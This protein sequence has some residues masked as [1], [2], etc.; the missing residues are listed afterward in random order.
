V[1]RIDPNYVNAYINRGNA[2]RKRGEL[3][4]A[5]AD[6][7]AALKLDPQNA[8][9]K[10]NRA[11]AVAE[12]A[13]AGPA[14]GGS[15]K[16][17]LDQATLE[18]CRSGKPSEYKSVMKACS[19]VIAAGDKVPLADRALAYLN[20]GVILGLD[21]KTDKAIDDI[22]QSIAL[23]PNNANAYSHR[24]EL[25]EK[26]DQLDYAVSDYD[27]AIRLD[28]KNGDYLDR[29][30]KDKAARNQPDLA[31]AD[32]TAALVLNPTDD[33]AYIWRGDALRQKGQYQAAIAEYDAALKLQPGMELAVSGRA[34][35]VAAQ[36]QAGATASAAPAGQPPPTEATNV[37]PVAMAGTRI[38]LVIGDSAYAAV[39][40]LPNPARDAKAVAEAL[41]ADGFSD[42][43]LIIDATRAD[44]V[45]ALNDFADKAAG[46][47]WAVVYFAGHG[48]EL[49]GTNY[50][51]PVDAR[52]KTD[53]DVQDEAVSL[54]RVI[55]SI[56]AA[57]KLKLVVLDAC[58]DNPFTVDMRLTGASRAIHRGLARIE[59]S[60]GTLVAYAAKGGEEAIDGDGTANS[61]FAAALVKRL[62]T[63]GLEVGKLF[64]LVHDDVLAATDRE[65]EPFVYG[66]LPGEDF[67]FRPQ[68]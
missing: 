46:A 24:A 52:L 9:A 42:V 55:A 1:L 18:L 48:L 19:V 2:H 17:A 37:S 41:K 64:R 56:Q 36:V 50:L 12:Q 49:D 31:I 11:Q 33:V 63:P 67:F 40:K 60:G 23:N 3:D 32:F 25:Y 20:R 62:T 66:A 54:D 29:R 51:I 59:P 43:R 13:K 6:Y 61:P 57:R 58:R 8:L 34:Q 68:P 30:G 7:D 28:P 10:N 35:A 45:Q 26:R 65:Q 47:D 44:L 5:F 27:I 21:W 38:A 39:A 15:A 53:R 16:G 14:P 22:S 4:D